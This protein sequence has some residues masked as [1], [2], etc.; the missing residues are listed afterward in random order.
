MVTQAELDEYLDEIRE[1]V[2][3]KCVERPPGGPPCA[4]LGKQCGVELHLPQLVEAIHEVQSPMIEPYL[5]HNRQAIC[6]NCA[7]L[8]SEI[9]P[10]PMD[11][12]SVLVVQAVETVDPRRV[13][14]PKENSE[15]PGGEADRGYSLEEICRQ[16]EQSSGTWTKCDWHTHF[17][18]AG[19]DLCG[20]L[21]QEA[22][23]MARTTRGTPVENDWRDAAVWLTLVERNAR[24]AEIQAALA[25]TAAKAGDWKMAQR[26]AHSAWALE[27]VTGRPL[28]LGFPLSWQQLHQ[29]IDQAIR[30]QENQAHFFAS[31]TTN[32]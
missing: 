23:T 17:G 8:H 3:S 24:Q 18:K 4:P 29:Y 28:R 1:Q 10:C 22:E 14:R 6:A 32:L 11:Y 21:S 12:L 30:S 31:L 16:Y 20:W 25:V 9:C 19:L 2:C 27:F 7:F 26:H 13:R 5:D 15:E